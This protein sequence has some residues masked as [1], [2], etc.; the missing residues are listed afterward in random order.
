[1][2]PDL[3]IEDSTVREYNMKMRSEAEHIRD[4]IVLIT[5]LTIRAILFGITR[6]M[7]LPESLKHRMELFERSGR[8]FKP[9]DD[10]F[11][12]NSWVQVMMGHTCSKK[13]SQHC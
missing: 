3:E 6:N 4:F 5:R 1:M 12:E 11:A 10:V 2:F 9:Q 7:D 13:L 8:V